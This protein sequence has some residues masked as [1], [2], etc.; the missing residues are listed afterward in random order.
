MKELNDQTLV[1]T[2]Q[3]REK[4]AMPSRPCLT[5]IAGSQMGRTIAL[6]NR[7]VL[8][9]RKE[10]CQIVIN[11]PGASRVHA[12]IRMIQGKP[13]LEDMG[14]TNGTFVNGRPIKLHW[15]HNQDRI[16]IGHST[17]L[18]FSY[19]DEVD[20]QY[21]RRLYE[22]ATLDAL[23]GLYNR[24]YLLDRLTAD[25]S[26]SRRHGRPISLLLLDVD[27]FKHI[28][29]VHGHL[30]G[31]AVLTQLAKLLKQASRSE[32]LVARWGGEEFMLIYRDVDT[33]GATISA[34]RIRRLISKTPFNYDS[35]SIDVTVSIGIA[36]LSSGDYG[37]QQEFIHAADQF[38]Y[39][40]KRK[41]RNRIES[42][43]T[44]DSVLFN[45]RAAA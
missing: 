17:L 30:A 7:Q 6:D 12:V 25:F 33:T 19:Q 31:D 21:Q 45:R 11:D 9:G 41:G 29:D 1:M 35:Q 34:E 18:R 38:L 44:S 13:A 23:T 14:S 26:H 5:Q 2:L 37:T 22:N 43:L 32:D 15:L 24:K 39:Q 10:D 42:V 8:L 16:A 27:Y 3:Q 40:A 4:K 28:N 36:S 20:E